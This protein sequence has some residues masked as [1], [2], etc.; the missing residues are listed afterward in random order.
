MAVSHASSS[1]CQ[2]LAV[3]LPVDLVPSPV[4]DEHIQRV[5]DHHT[6]SGD[7]TGKMLLSSLTNDVD[8][9]H[10]IEPA[11]S[12]DS[13]LTGQVKSFKLSFLSDFRIVHV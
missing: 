11:C 10:V 7:V 4:V 2:Q 12:Y 1:V 13:S 8:I 9:G 6:S 3:L 5:K